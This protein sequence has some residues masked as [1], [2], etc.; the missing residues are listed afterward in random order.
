VFFYE[1]H[2]FPT[3]CVV[4]VLTDFVVFFSRITSNTSSLFAG[5]V[6]AVS[7]LKLSSSS[8]ARTS[9]HVQPVVSN[10]QQPVTNGSLLDTD[11]AASA[12]QPQFDS[13]LSNTKLIDGTDVVLQCHVTGSPV[14]NVSQLN[15]HTG[16]W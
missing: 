11:H 7:Q 1:S 13:K 3:L 16:Y 9:D 6:S 4:I 2:N 12:S 14:P 5:Q 15:S 10:V 8:A